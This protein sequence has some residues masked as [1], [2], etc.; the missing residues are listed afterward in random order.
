MKLLDLEGVKWIE[1]SFDDVKKLSG[2]LFVAWRRNRG[3]ATGV[4]TAAEAT[5]KKTRTNGPPVIS[6]A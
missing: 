4:E 1:E 2:Q 5:E 6:D 3:G